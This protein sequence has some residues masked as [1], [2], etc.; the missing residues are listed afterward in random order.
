MFQCTYGERI[1]VSAQPHFLCDRSQNS[2]LHIKL[3]IFFEELLMLNN[4]GSHCTI[5]NKPVLD[6]RR[7]EASVIHVLRFRERLSGAFKYSSTRSTVNTSTFIE[8]LLANGIHCVSKKSL[9]PHEACWTDNKNLFKFDYTSQM[10][11]VQFQ[12]Q[13]RSIVHNDR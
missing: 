5:L 3:E 10:F 6:E 13:T 8:E 7:I 1:T 4:A 9:F 2:K 12:S 11:I